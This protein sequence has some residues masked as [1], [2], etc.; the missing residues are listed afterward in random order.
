MVKVVYWEVLYPLGLTVPGVSL[1][2]LQHLAATMTKVRPQVLKHNGFMGGDYLM[3]LDYGR[4]LSVQL[5]DELGIDALVRK[6]MYEYI[7]ALDQKRSEQ[8]AAIAEEKR[9]GRNPQ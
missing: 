7:H 4:T 1:E 9:K 6:K 8:R 3:P 2:R 5:A